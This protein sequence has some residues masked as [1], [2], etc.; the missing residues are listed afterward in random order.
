M[1]V[2]NFV[3]LAPGVPVKLHFKDHRFVE[4]VIMD[5]VFEVPRTVKTLLFLVDERD[6]TPVDM[7]YS[8]LS[9]RLASDFAGDLPG[10][11]YRGYTYTIVK[12]APGTVPPR[13]VERRPR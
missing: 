7:T 4:R 11:A 5:A 13:I 2:E 6:G 9:E 10:K 12:D 8:V 1:A 3:K